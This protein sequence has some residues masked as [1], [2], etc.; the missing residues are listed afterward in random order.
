VAQLAGFIAEDHAHGVLDLHG[1]RSSNAWC[2][3]RQPQGRTTARV[4]GGAYGAGVAVEELHERRRAQAPSVSAAKQRLKRD[5][6]THG[7]WLSVRRE[8]ASKA[9]SER[10]G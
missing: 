9:S 3:W 10:S 1:R 8:E 7:P 5:D 6:L 4:R 2:W